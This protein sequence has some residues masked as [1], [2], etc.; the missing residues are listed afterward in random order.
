MPLY[1]IFLINLFL[2]FL[3][4]KV[5]AKILEN[6]KWDNVNGTPCVTVSKTPNSSDY[7]EIGINKK[8]I[9]KQEIIESGA[10]DTNDISFKSPDIGLLEFKKKLGVASS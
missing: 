5:S 4:S 6:C 7:N 3:F 10:I 8:I 1:K 9:T 2:V